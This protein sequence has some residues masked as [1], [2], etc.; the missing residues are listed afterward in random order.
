M[1]ACVLSHVQLFAISWSVTHQ[2]PLCIGFSRQEYWNGLPFPPPGDLPDP[3]T[4]HV[5]PALAGGFFITEPPGTLQEVMRLSQTTQTHTHI[6]TLIL[7]FGC[8]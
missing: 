2:A 6:Y 8:P 7:V 4:E 3:R 5:S 1:R